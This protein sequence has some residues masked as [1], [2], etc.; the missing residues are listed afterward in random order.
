MEQN[1]NTGDR[2]TRVLRVALLA[3]GAWYL[4]AFVVVAGSRLTYTHELEWMEGNAIAHMARILAGEPLYHAPEL[5]H[6][7][8]MYTPLYYYVS[9]LVAAVTGPTFLALRLVS[10]GSALGILAL[11]F[12]FVQ[13]ETGDRTAAVLAACTFAATYQIGDAWLDVGRV[14][15][16]FL[17]LMLGSVYC[18]RFGE[19]SRALALAGVLA[20]LSF[21]TKQTAAIIGL[22]VGLYLLAADWRRG[23][24]YCA[25]VGGVVGVAT[26]V[27]EVTSG[28]WFLYYITLAGDHKWRL[29]FFIDF[30]TKD[31][32]GPLPFACLAAVASLVLWRPRGAR[33]PLIYLL[34]GVGFLCGSWYTRILPLGHYNVLIPA[35]LWISLMVGIGLHQILSRIEGL[36]EARRWRLL[37]L[38]AGLAQMAILIYDPRGKLPS[39]TDARAGD[40]MVDKIKAI[41]GPV[42]VPCHDY[43]VGLAGKEGHAH[44]IPIW[45]SW[46]SKPSAGRK[47]L[48][49]DIARRLS[50]HHYGA[51]ILDQN[52]IGVFLRQAVE[53]FYEPR[54]YVFKRTSKSFLQ[55][56]GMQTRPS[57]IYLPRQRPG[58]R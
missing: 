57:V 1:V 9:A 33:F 24:W 17:L 34:S 50:T 7:P 45:E 23:A 46:A 19:G 41:K 42:L 14:D 32:L 30:W 28:G 38:A 2:A 37:V 10:F 3:A 4:L 54:A 13:R 39:E 47:R 35:F 43:L 31:L 16:L 52:P 26:A 53:R 8:N 40:L 55:V 51:V 58:P 6:L 15:S 25:G 18:I 36:G 27:L 56:T 44:L 29:W 20:G 21:L 22:P 49:D 11:I 12:R 5:A 48:L